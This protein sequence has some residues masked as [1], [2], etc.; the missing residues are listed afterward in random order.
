MLRELRFRIIKLISALFASSYRIIDPRRSPLPGQRT[1]IPVRPLALDRSRFAMIGEEPFWMRLGTLTLDASYEMELNNVEII[2]KGIVV[3]REGA[4]VLESTIFQQEY[5][6]RSYQNHL[7][8]F[9]RFLPATRHTHALSLI[10]YLD[11]N[12]FHWML[13]SVGRLMLVREQLSDPT[14]HLLIDS[15]APRFVRESIGFLFEVPQERI[16]NDG[17]RRRHVEHLLLPSYPHT[18]NERTGWANIY[19][20]EVIRWI[21]RTAL[22]RIGPAGPKRNFIITRRHADQRRML[23]AEAIIDRFPEKRFTIIEPEEFSFREQVELFAN[24][25]MIIA[26]H[27]AG[28][29][30]L[31]FARDAQVIEFYPHVR[32]E[33]DSSYFFQITSAL[34]IRHQLITYE[35][36][37]AQQSLYMNEQRLSEL[38]RL[39]K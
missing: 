39:E 33:K 2:G 3:T 6:R 7:I 13:E 25:G 23:N 1:L 30:N 26:M 18:R 5:L 11:R 15:D 32:E 14:L 4:V 22:D 34:G 36:S 12:Y 17:S 38:E 21:N 29:T 37:D 19:P 31:L 28:L 8:A 35:P 16:I 20:P 9:R 27:G 10:N 24:A